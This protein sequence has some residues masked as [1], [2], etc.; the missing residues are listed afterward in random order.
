MDIDKAVT[1]MQSAVASVNR[2]KE[3]IKTLEYIEK[4]AR[5]GYVPHLNNNMILKSVASREL[6]AAAMKIEIDLSRA[7]AVGVVT[8]ARVAIVAT[9]EGK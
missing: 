4:S 1:D 5:D 2:H 3:R 7:D 8:N 9:C 6:I